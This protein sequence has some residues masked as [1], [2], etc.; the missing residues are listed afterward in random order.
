MPVSLHR[1]TTM[2][3]SDQR[4]IE[5]VLIEV[6]AE[7]SVRVLLPKCFVADEPYQLFLGLFNDRVVGV[8]LLENSTI[9]AFHVHPATRNRGVGRRMMALLAQQV[10]NLELAPD[11]R[12]TV[13]KSMLKSI[14]GESAS[15]AP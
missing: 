2:G 10:S 5:R 8:V 4:A 1:L 7:D 12:F 6:P 9:E 14:Q 15:M 3:T 11:V 13:L